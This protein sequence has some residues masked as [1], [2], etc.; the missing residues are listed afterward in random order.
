MSD[1]INER[2]RTANGAPAPGGP[3]RGALG[4]FASAFL[5]RREATILLVALGLMIYFQTSTDG[6]FL[7]H[8]NLVNLAQSTAP[9]AIIAVGQVLLLVSGEID[10]SA[11]AVYTFTPF[12][13]HYLIDFYGV[14]PI[15]AI[16]LAVLIAAGIG[17]LNGFVVVVFKVPAF[18]ATLGM[19]FFVGGVMLTTSNAFP[20][21]I[22]QAA[23]GAV[24]RWF[25]LAEWSQLIWCLLIVAFFQVVLSRTRW[26]LHT[27]ATGGNR[28]GAAE[29]GI[30]TGRIKIGNFMITGGLS[31]FAGILEVFRT[32]TIDPTLSGAD[33]ASAMFTAVS[34]AVIGGTAL[35]GGSGTVVGAL[36]G[37]FVLAELRNG[38]NLIGISA[39][40]FNI[41]L[42][43]A[44]LGSMILNVYLAN[45]RR[46]GRT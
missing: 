23:Q 34:A 30:K 18:V 39:N 43:L 44:I 33:F 36:F 35:A 11:G 28:L 9:F 10:L 4:R 42:G 5:Q 19:L 8:N 22:P 26:G 16:I 12:M 1:V 13:M 32:Q 21:E 6:V 41:I 14:Y 27:I 20:A 29:A 46:A 37:A 25:G 24:Q 40:P 17:F 45:L 3:G 31:G 7:S 2:T 15:P 38:F